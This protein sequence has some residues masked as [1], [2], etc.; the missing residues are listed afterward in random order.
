MSKANG[1]NLI[2]RKILVPIDFSPSSEAALK[3][4]TALAE[5]L[6]AEIHLVH[7]IPMFTVAKMPDF[8]SEAEFIGAAKKEAER[9]F[10]LCREDLAKKGIMA[11]ASIVTGN[12]V[13]AS[14]LNAIKREHIDMVVVST[15]GLTGW[16]PLVF[17]SIAEKLVKLVHIPV[18]L[19]RTAKPEDKVQA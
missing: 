18:L 3:Q 4:A 16:H 13:T 2:P 12:D 14:I 9:Y 1:Y 7:V 11:T 17:G 19:I 6:H 8:I 15:H 5:Q 10:V